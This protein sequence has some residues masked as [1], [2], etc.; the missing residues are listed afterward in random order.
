MLLG[1][2]SSVWR[3]LSSVRYYSS[4]LFCGLFITYTDDTAVFQFIGFCLRVYAFEIWANTPSN[5]PDI[6]FKTIT[7]EDRLQRLVRADVTAEAA[8]AV[9]FQ[10]QQPTASRLDQPWQSAMRPRQVAPRPS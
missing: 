9:L 8:Q 6:V 5:Y 2:R 7:K 3:R 1:E 10:R 4:S